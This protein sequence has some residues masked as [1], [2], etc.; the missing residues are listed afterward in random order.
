[1]I[2]K[3]S[4]GHLFRCDRCLEW[5]LIDIADEQKAIVQVEEEGWKIGKRHLCEI[6]RR[7]NE[8]FNN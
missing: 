8:R 1:M 7:N 5:Y 4:G 3:V 6:C 2:R